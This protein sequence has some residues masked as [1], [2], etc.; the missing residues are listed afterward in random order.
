MGS[1]VVEEFLKAL[2][3]PEK[4]EYSAKIA[5]VPFTTL[6]DAHDDIHVLTKEKMGIHSEDTTVDVYCNTKAYEAVIWVDKTKVGSTVKK[7]HIL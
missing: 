4:M 3:N 1:V 5:I 6:E 7:L 2:T